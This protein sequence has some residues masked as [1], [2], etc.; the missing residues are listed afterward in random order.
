MLQINLSSYISNKDEY[1]KNKNQHGYKLIFSLPASST[2]NIFF[3][4]SNH[5]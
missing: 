3:P 5:I 1:M 2:E 4:T